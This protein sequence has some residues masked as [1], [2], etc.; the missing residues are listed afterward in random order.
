[1]KTENPVT[2]SSDWLQNRD[3]RKR[4]WSSSPDIFWNFLSKSPPSFH[5]LRSSSN[6]DVA[7]ENCLD[8]GFP[9][10]SGLIRHE[11]DRPCSLCITMPSI[12]QWKSEAFCCLV[13]FF[14]R[15]SPSRDLAAKRVWWKQKTICY[16]FI[17]IVT[18]QWNARRSLLVELVRDRVRGGQ[19]TLVHAQSDDVVLIWRHWWRLN[20]RRNAVDVRLLFLI[21]QHFSQVVLKVNAHV[22]TATTSE[23]IRFRFHPLVWIVKRGISWALGAK[24]QRRRNWIFKAAYPKWKF[25][26][27]FI[28]HPGVCKSAKVIVLRKMW[29]FLFPRFRPSLNVILGTKT[30]STKS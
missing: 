23:Q 9:F 21:P 17:H 22:R 12:V 20:A 4:D 19:L 6:E 15:R 28:F 14:K 1:M 7:I 11:R 25:T 26:E 30:N 13:Y 8:R 3:Y 24:F 29:R 2:K 5:F 10:R 16:I 18:S 27:M